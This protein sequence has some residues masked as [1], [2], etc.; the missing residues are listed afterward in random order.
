MKIQILS[1]CFALSALYCSAQSLRSKVGDN[2]YTINPAAAFEVESATKGFLPPRMTYDERNNITSPATG[3]ILYCTNCGENGQLQIF[4]GTKWTNAIGGTAEIDFSRILEVIGDVNNPVT[5]EQLHSLGITEAI[6]DY[7]E[8]YQEAI[9]N[10]D[11]SSIE[12]SG[13]LEGTRTALKQSVINTNRAVSSILTQL[14]NEADEPNSI[15]SRVTITQLTRLLGSAEIATTNIRDF[16]KAF[17]IFIDTN[18]TY[19]SSPATLTEVRQTINEVVFEASNIVN[20]IVNGAMGGGSDF[21]IADLKTIGITNAVEDNLT[22]YH[23]Y[24]NLRPDLFGYGT[25]P[26]DIQ[27]Q[28]AN[29]N[30]YVLAILTKIGNLADYGPSSVPPTFEEFEFL[31]FDLL[32]SY[33]YTLGSLYQTFIYYCTINSD[34]FSSPATI[35]EV[36]AGVIVV[37]N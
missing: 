5:V 19:L 25:T 37:M 34:L 35:A 28:I 31:N 24:F 26:S 4:N 18:P 9:Y 33:P 16:E 29:A 7:E 11:S 21:T 2:P 17:Q 1:L 12:I 3:L 14:G 22:A 6:T 23:R 27:Y 13:T 30:S 15:P 8:A 10:Y 20:N 32:Q 36:R